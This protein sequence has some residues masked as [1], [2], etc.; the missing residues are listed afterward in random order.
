MEAG[1]NK[2]EEKMAKPLEEVKRLTVGQLA[3]LVHAIGGLVAV[4][5]ILGNKDLAKRV[6]KF[7]GEAMEEKYGVDSTF[8]AMVDYVAPTFA[9]LKTQFS[10]VNDFYNEAD[11]KVI[12][13]C[14]WEPRELEF[15]YVHLD[16]I[17]STE[18]V[19]AKME[20]RNLRPAIYE[21]GL[22]FAKAH[23]DEQRKFPIVMLGSV[24]VDPNGDRSVAC[25]DKANG[26]R[27]LNLFMVEG[28]WGG[29]C[30]FLAVSK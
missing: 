4:K 3:A 16:R 30:R 13:I 19:L 29:Y 2:P 7:I 8:R 24:C 9:G 27:Y 23:P 14:N 1:D 22:G 21:E 5:A 18:E 11:F 28:G 25:L 6:A 10:W 20:R 12:N 15:V 17:S 26:G